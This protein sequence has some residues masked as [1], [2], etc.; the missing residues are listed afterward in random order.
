MKTAVNALGM[1]GTQYGFGRRLP[2]NAAEILAGHPVA[3]N[4]VA[5]TSEVYG[6]KSVPVPVG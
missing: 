3:G 5:G 4:P 2:T 6:R 1:T